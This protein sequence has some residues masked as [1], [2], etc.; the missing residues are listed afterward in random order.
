MPLERAF[1]LMA[2]TS[3]NIRRASCDSSWSGNGWRIESERYFRE[4]IL[5]LATDQE[6]EVPEPQRSA[7][8]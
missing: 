7:S 8:H 1:T 4:S 5:V 3:V 6:A 2:T